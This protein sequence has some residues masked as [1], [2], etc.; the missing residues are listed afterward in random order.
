MYGQ[1]VLVFEC[2]SAG[3]VFPTRV[4]EG[5]LEVFEVVGGVR[6]GWRCSRWLKVFEVVGGVRA[7]WKCARWL[8]V[9]EVAA[10][11]NA[12]SPANLA[13]PGQARPSQ[14]KGIWAIE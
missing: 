5:W 4:G 7:G 13:G 9:F 6:G 2:V 3:A 12:R 11:R 14:A 8:E 1:E 10:R